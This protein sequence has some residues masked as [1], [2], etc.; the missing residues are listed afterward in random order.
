MYI[1]LIMMI[2]KFL[3]QKNQRQKCQHRPRKAVKN[4]RASQKT[5]AKLALT[6]AQPESHICFKLRC[7]DLKQNYSLLL[8]KTQLTT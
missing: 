5:E 6:A 2:Q 4:L 3:F 7:R 1:F 8:P